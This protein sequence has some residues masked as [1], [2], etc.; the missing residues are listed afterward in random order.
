MTGNI[1][2]ERGR[3]D[4]VRPEFEVMVPCTPAEFGDFISGLLGKPQ[5]IEKIIFGAFEIT[6]NDV[7]NTFHLVQQRISHQNQATLI[8]F[9]TRVFYDD[10][11]SVLL[12]SID[13]FE[14]YAE[15]RPIA[16]VGVALSWTYL[17]QFRGRATPEKQE[18]NLSF[19]GTRNDIDS[20][21]YGDG[22]PTK[23]SQHWTPAAC[24]FRIAHTE[25]TWGIDIESLLTGHVKTFLQQESWAKRFARKRS[26]GIGILSSSIFM[27]GSI[28]GVY[29]TAKDFTNSYIEKINAIKA[30]AKGAQADR[31]I[32]EQVELI[33]TVISTGAWPRFTFTSVI[34]LFI[35]LIASLVVGLWIEAKANT[36]PCSYVLLSKQA[37]LRRKKMLDRIRRDW[38]MFYLSVAVSIL[39]GVFSNVIFTKFFSSI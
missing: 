15:V 37:D 29:F 39:A 1:E 27:L 3:A 11:S 4:H 38:A 32:S 20:M 6:R 24:I 7:I 25:R 33:L 9:T 18:I 31:V 34:F 19:Q 36:T 8:Q 2:P 21:N 23:R 10:D 13:D 5:T 26:G 14:N 12:N 30:G 28:F 17:I 35:S 22:F 16:S